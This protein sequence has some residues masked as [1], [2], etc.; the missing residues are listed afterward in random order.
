[1]I[2]SLSKTILV[3]SL[4]FLLPASLWAAQMG[5]ALIP[6]KGSDLKGQPYDL[7]DSIGKK[8]V[9]LIF[10]ASWCP[11]CKTEV[12][13]MNKLAEKFRPRGME[14]I[15]VNIGFNDSIERAQAFV[16]KTG[17]T[18]PAYFDGTETIAEKYRLQGVPTVIIADKHGIVRFRNFTAPEI[19]EENF[20]QLMAD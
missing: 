13:R 17:M 1:M 20:A 12:P 18:Y 15:A 19:S 4:L 14:F 10:W 11:T 5:Q 9:M 7:Q 16:K 2:R 6:F 3:L 8:P